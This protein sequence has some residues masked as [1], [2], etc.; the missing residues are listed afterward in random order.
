MLFGA[1]GDL[2][3]KETMLGLR[4]RQNSGR[5]SARLSEVAEQ[6][7]AGSVS[8]RRGEGKGKIDKSVTLPRERKR[9]EAERL[10]HLLIS[11]SS[12]INDAVDYRRSCEALLSRR[13]CPSLFATIWQHNGHLL[14]P[15]RSRHALDRRGSG[16]CVDDKGR[17][18][19]FHG[20]SAHLY[21]LGLDG[22]ITVKVTARW[23]RKDFS[24]ILCCGLLFDSAAP[25]IRQDL[26]QAVHILA[27]LK[28]LLVSGI[29]DT[30]LIRHYG[31]KV[32]FHDR[33]AHL[34]WLGLDG[35]IT[36]K[37]TA[38]WRLEGGCLISDFLLDLVDIGEERFQ[39]DSVLWVAL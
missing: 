35:L 4:E 8:A 17:K 20:R 10:F 1:F 15:S 30:A 27:E 3:G 18:I 34:Y 36:V 29:V 28:G 21:W 7:G 2:H 25:W 24:K 5:R 31:R 19:S 14:C 6:G 38:R 33:S 22:L 37:V 39:Q 9:G 16:A 32:S 26:L 12:L 11:G 23:V 13:S